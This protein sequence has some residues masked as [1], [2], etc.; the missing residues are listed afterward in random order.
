[1]HQLRSHPVDS[2]VSHHQLEIPAA[3][4]SLLTVSRR[5]ALQSWPIHA[6]GIEEAASRNRQLAP[7]LLLMLLMLFLLLQPQS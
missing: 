1:M 4:R 7:L 3:F 2:V 6:G 5:L